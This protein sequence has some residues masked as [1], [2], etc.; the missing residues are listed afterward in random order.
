[1]PTWIEVSTDWA[2][3][4]S[5][6]A[7]V[8]VYGNAVGHVSEIEAVLEDPLPSTTRRRAAASARGT[9]IIFHDAIGSTNV[10]SLINSPS[11]KP[12]PSP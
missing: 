7:V 5:G 2:P 6:S 10:L 12:A 8:D 1:M 3:G 11:T 9:L 4:S